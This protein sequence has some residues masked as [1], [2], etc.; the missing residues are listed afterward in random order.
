[1][2]KRHGLVLFLFG[3][4][5][6]V[7]LMAAFPDVLGTYFFFS[8]ALFI[9]ITVAVLFAAAAAVWLALTRKRHIREPKQSILYQGKAFLVWFISHNLF[10]ALVGSIS[11]WGLLMLFGPYPWVIIFSAGALACT[12]FALIGVF[13]IKYKK[14]Q[15]LGLCWQSPIPDGLPN[16]WDRAAA[17]MILRERYEYAA[18]HDQKQPTPVLWSISRVF[19][20]SINHGVERKVDLMD[21]GFPTKKLKSEGKHRIKVLLV[22]FLVTA[23]LAAL[24]GL[25]G[26]TPPPWD[27]VPDGWPSSKKPQMMAKKQ[28]QDQEQKSGSDSKTEDRGENEKQ[29][30]K[31]SKDSQQK[32]Q[33]S[34]QTGDNQDGKSKSGSGAGD[35]SSSKSN[36]T[37]A[38]DSSEGQSQQGQ[39][40]KEGQSEGS[41]REQS[42]K[43]PKTPK[44][45]DTP[46]TQGADSTGKGG[47]KQEQQ[48]KQPGE[49]QEGK[50]KETKGKGDK[51]ETGK[52]GDKKGKEG[53]KGTGDPGKYDSEGGQGQE[54]EGKGKQGK[55]G[56]GGQK[57][58]DQEGGGGKQE[59][60]SSAQDKGQGK[61]E[62]S[63]QEQG[64]KGSGGEDKGDKGQQPGDSQQGGADQGQE[65]T[66][67]RG[68]GG[69]GQGLGDP[70]HVPETL[71]EPEPITKFPSRD[72]KMVTL[73]LPTL[74]A[75]A[76]A[77]DK[78]KKDQSQKDKPD[79]NQKKQR[80]PTTQFRAGKQDRRISKPDQFL[81]NWILMLLKQKAKK[82]K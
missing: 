65:A 27:R 78:S 76:P 68:S 9:L 54:Q 59:G 72:T 37:G 74:N 51:A 13:I 80:A 66:K 28:K 7:G 31:D 61:G 79:A 30:R 50:G 44:S 45:P 15:M 20:R 22:L 48:D 23:A 14:R 40:G 52:K 47:S 17:A 67:S 21:R 56:E 77:G 34:K 6:I 39:E 63:G 81:P 32:G 3:F 71:P 2:I 1:M 35:S 49:G 69:E 18:E 73:D 33:E 25:L 11:I 57:G 53:E 24:P 75:L 36:G 70:D 4:S 82:R 46:D 62:G 41:S 29:S 38:G 42:A 10:W 19:D 26:L 55:P 16:F 5:I 58:Q 43:G 12:C 60:E 64:L 8:G